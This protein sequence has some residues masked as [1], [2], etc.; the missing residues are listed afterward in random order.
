MEL[1]A[2]KKKTLLQ[3]YSRKRSC[4]LVKLVIEREHQ[5]VPVGSISYKVK[6]RRERLNSTIGIGFGLPPVIVVAAYDPLA[7]RLRI[8]SE[9]SDSP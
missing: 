2:A 8:F 1:C 5:L 9:T 7:S 4:Q 3:T 6:D